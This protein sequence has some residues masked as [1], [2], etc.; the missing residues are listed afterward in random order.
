MPE[1]VQCPHCGKRLR[2]P[3]NLLG[4]AVSCAG[5]EQDFVAKPVTT[6]PDAVQD[7]PS[8][9]RPPR[10]DPEEEPEERPARRR[11]GDDREDDDEDDRPRRRRARND[12][13]EDDNDRP[14]RRRARDDEDEDDRPRRRGGRGKALASA[15]GPGIAFLIVGILG[16]LMGGVYV[17]QAIRGR[18]FFAP[19]NQGEQYP[20][21]V[22]WL[23]AFITLVW[24]LVVTLG[25]VK[26]MRL[27]SWGSVMVACIFAMLPCN[28]C[29]LA[30]LPIGIWGLIVLAQPE[31][32]KGFR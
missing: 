6:S 5:C 4:K 28:P 11:R 14:R 22:F 24:G 13:D 21:L 26:L 8:A 31:V 19:D 25:G 9:R 12:E 7:R 17:I 10:D 29:C 15:Q 23:I 3:D 18:T 1:I 2:V 32:K 20:V 16:L 30:G 27:E